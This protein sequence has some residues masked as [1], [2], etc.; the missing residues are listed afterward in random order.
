MLSKEDKLKLGREA[1]AL[2]A[3]CKDRVPKKLPEA[4]LFATMVANVA[5]QKAGSTSF[6]M[7]K[8]VFD[9][10]NIV[11]DYAEKKLDELHRT[12]HAPGLQALANTAVCIH[13]TILEAIQRFSNLLASEYEV[14][15]RVE[16]HDPLKWTT[17]LKITV[18]STKQE[19]ELEAARQKL[20]EA[21]AAVESALKKRKEDL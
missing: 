18:I 19:D 9:F 6:V 20:T 2:V 1:D 3:Q 15:I 12:Y 7:A 4:S 16:I 8:D 17:P 5:S 14:K 11:C 10:Y 21:F 13:L